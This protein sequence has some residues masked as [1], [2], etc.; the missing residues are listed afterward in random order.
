[1]GKTK[2]SGAKPK[3]TKKPIKK[4]AD[5][6]YLAMGGQNALAGMPGPRRSGGM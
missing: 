1:V 5:K 6:K 4:K 2:K 3:R